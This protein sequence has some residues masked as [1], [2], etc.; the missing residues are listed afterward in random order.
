MTL[1]IGNLL[2]MFFLKMLIFYGRFGILDVDYELNF[3]ISRRMV[4]SRACGDEYVSNSRECN[5]D[6]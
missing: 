3:G 6:I 4:V 5:R 1:I 2:K